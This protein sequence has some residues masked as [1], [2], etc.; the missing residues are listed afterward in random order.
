[1]KDITLRQIEYFLAVLDRGSVSAAALYSNVSQATVSAAL[2]QLEKQLGVTLL[3]RGPARKASPTSAGRE[4]GFHARA[5]VS[6][7]AEAVESVD[8]DATALRGP[9]RVGCIPPVAPRML[10]GVA[11]AFGQRHPDVDVELIEA[12]PMSI[13]RMVLGGEID[14]AVMYRKQVQIDGL[15]RHTLCEVQL[16]ALFAHDHPLAG[17]TEVEI[18]EFIDEPLILLDAPPTAEIL[19]SMV[20]DIGLEPRVRWLIPNV[21]T[22]R[23]MVSMGLGYSLTYAVPHPTVRAFQG[24]SLDYVPVTDAGLSNT[25]VGV[26]LAEARMS[27]KLS[28]VLSVLRAVADETDP[29]NWDTRPG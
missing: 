23:S 11:A 21:E 13:Q 27:K 8:E 10:P 7:V 5:I 4:F 2:S 3:S 17:R 1:M 20:R 15:R 12:R 14:I 6:S 25:L 18:G 16:Y 28:T 29:A 9:L 26:A 22:I 19:L 24:L